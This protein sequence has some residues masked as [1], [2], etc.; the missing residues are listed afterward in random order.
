MSA[1]IPN[2]ALFAPLAFPHGTSMKNRFMLAPLTNT[3]SN[4]DG[5]LG[6]AEHHWLTM[7]A[8]GGFGMTMTCAS[9]VQR[10]GQAFIG[11]LGIWD[12]KHLPGLTRLAKDIKAEGSLAIVQLHHGGNKGEEK[13][14]GIRPVAP[15]EDP[16]TNSRALTTAE[17]Q[18][19]VDD[20]AAAAKRAEKAGFDGVELHGAHSYI[21]CRFMSPTLNQRTDQYGGSLE[22]RIR[23][24]MEILEKIRARCRPDFTVGIRIS[25]ER[26]GVVIS[27]MLQVTKMLV[28]C[29]H[30]DFIDFS[31]WDCFK[32]PEDK[33]YAGK[34]LI[35]HFMAIDRKNVKFAVAGKIMNP[36]TAQACLDA[37]ADFV[38]LGRA[39]I[40]HH[41]Y[42]LLA[43]KPGFKPVATPVTPDWLKKEGLSPQFIGY[44]RRW[45]GFVT[46]EEKVT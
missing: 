44:M 21:L 7:R 32:E 42:P 23:L 28:D 18:Q 11:Q 37:G 1:P 12:D 38:A 27:E 34:S 13:L 4:A 25:P 6:E 31:L 26:Y 46:E 40:L 41:D 17:V 20:F 9:H 14:S 36:A 33:A 45:A 43:A 5:T 16:E 35:A 15:S 29:G 22:N 24:V 19:L 2:S 8:K 39:A 10:V 30:L 3:Q